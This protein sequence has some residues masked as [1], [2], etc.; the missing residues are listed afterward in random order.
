M[1]ALRHFQE[2]IISYTNSVLDMMKGEDPQLFE[3]S[4]VNWD[5]VQAVDCEFFIDM[6]GEGGFRV[7]IEEASPDNIAFSTYV[8]KA[9]DTMAGYRIEVRTEW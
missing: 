2:E 9:F 1:N 5:A 7:V 3:G 6:N 8:Q 4:A